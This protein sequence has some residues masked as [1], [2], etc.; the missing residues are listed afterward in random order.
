MC[1]AAALPSTRPYTHGYTCKKIMAIQS[2]VRRIH[3]QQFLQSFEHFSSQTLAIELTTKN[4]LGWDMQIPMLETKRK[5]HSAC[6]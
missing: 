1:L 3:N 5:L 4:F 6:F 2:I